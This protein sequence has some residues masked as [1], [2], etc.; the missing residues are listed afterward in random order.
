MSSEHGE[1][2]QLGKEDENS[3]TVYI[4]SAKCG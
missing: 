2:R 4:W 3:E 1:L